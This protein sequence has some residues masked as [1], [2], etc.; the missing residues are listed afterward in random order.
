MDDSGLSEGAVVQ[1][2]FRSNISQTWIVD[3]PGTTEKQEV[4]LWS[5]AVHKRKSQAQAYADSFGD[6]AGLYA[7][8]VRDGL[9]IREKPEIQAKQIYRLRLDETIKLLRK[10]TGSLVETGGQPLPGDWFLAMTEEGTRGYVFSNQ[11]AI[12][13]TFTEDRP[14]A[15][16]SAPVQDARMM[17]IF[18]KTWRPDYFITM[19]ESG[20]VDLT[21][22]QLRFGIFTDP[23]NRQL[24]VELPWFSRAY[25]YTSIDRQAD[26]SFLL[27]PS[28][29][30]VHFS[31]AG[32][33]LF[34]PPDSDLTASVRRLYQASTAVAAATTDQAGNQDSTAS[35]AAA[36]QNQAEKISFVFKQQTTDPRNVIAAEERRRINVLGMMVSAGEYFESLYNGIL[37]ITSTGRFTWMN[38][39]TMMP[40]VIPEALGDTGE[41]SMDLF[42]S[43]ELA[44]TWQGAFSLRFDANRR[45]VVS[46]VYRADQNSLT[47]VPVAADAVRLSTVVAVDPEQAIFFMRY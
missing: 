28:G 44:G 7:V 39:E 14:V 27:V 32:D 4:S 42:L 25:T 43:P 13:N 10:V 35:Q 18:D 47:L 37:V 23:A 24:R 38:Y 1:V 33:L 30:R 16:L 22:Y 2:Y 36:E 6:M 45:T 15:A 46:F 9:L 11:L 19:Q 26:G 3:V 31:A 40:S 5:L 21:R 29:A 8:T 20:R 41:I 12:W 34:T 17:D